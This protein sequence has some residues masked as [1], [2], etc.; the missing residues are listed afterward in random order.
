MT[1]EKELLLLLGNSAHLK[2]SIEVRNYL[3]YHLMHPSFKTN[4]EM[5]LLFIGPL[6]VAD[7]KHKHDLLKNISVLKKDFFPDKEIREKAMKL[8]NKLEE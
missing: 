8:I 1:K 2:N 4:E 6:E 5:A 7:K 3:G